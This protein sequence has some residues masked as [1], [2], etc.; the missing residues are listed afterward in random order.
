MNKDF[1]KLLS[2]FDSEDERNILSRAALVAFSGVLTNVAGTYDGR[3][4]F[5]NLYLGVVAPPASGKGVIGYARALLESVD[6]YYL[7]LNPGDYHAKTAYEAG[8]RVFG[9]PAI[10][11]PPNALYQKPVPLVAADITKAMLLQQLQANYGSPTVL[12]HDEI[13][14]LVAA[15]GGEHG[16]GLSA[17]LR[18]GF[19][20]E[21]LSQQLKT[22]FEHLVIKEPK[23]AVA[24]AGTPEQMRN[25]IGQVENGLF[26]RFLL[27]FTSESVGWR[28]LSPDST[29]GMARRSAI[30]DLQKLVL[31][32]HLFQLQHPLVVELTDDQW[33]ELNH[34]GEKAT[35]TVAVTKGE[36]L[37]ALVKRHA[38][39]LFK[40][41]MVLT[42]LRR[43]DERGAESVR[44][45]D[46]RDFEMAKKI[47]AS[48]LESSLAFASEKLLKTKG[49]T[50]YQT[51][52]KA[53]PNTF[54]RKKAIEVGSKLGMSPR[55]VDR[56]LSYLKSTDAIRKDSQNTYFK[57]IK[58]EN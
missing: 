50:P 53:L 25:L 15:M 39:M 30:S 27:Y 19:Q 8:M 7:G 2:T 4:V 33:N 32:L 14:A 43:A 34:F 1:L 6:D 58:N 18:A 24:L 3:I 49:L 52:Y 35:A 56:A 11:F 55:T 51:L 28:P 45:V 29:A 26:S 48:S 38:L 20:N 41:C 44:K 21:T 31:N 57:S 42:A 37:L 47:V 46:T 10:P 36:E 40:V 9:L 54:E 12:I 23:V 5:P 22:K 16:K 17:V 13:D